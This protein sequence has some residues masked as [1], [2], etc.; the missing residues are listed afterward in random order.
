MTLHFLHVRGILLALLWANSIVS[1]FVVN[2]DRKMATFATLLV[3]M[4]VSTGAPAPVVDQKLEMAF[5]KDCKELG[6]PLRLWFPERRLVLAAGEF[7]IEPD[8]RIRLAPCSIGVLAEKKREGDDK[9][10]ALT[11]IRSDCV[12]LTLDRPATKIQDLVDRKIIAIE[13]SGG[14]KLSVG[15]P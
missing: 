11:T 2:G 7:D 9:P 3:V 5:G 1:H 12:Y 10:R 6:R 13:A 8:G 15:N 4:L 14:L